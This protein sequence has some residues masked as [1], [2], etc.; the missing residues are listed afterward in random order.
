MVYSPW[1]PC[2]PLREYIRPS[3]NRGCRISHYKR[4]G[5]HTPRSELVKGTLL[6]VKVGFFGSDEN[7]VRV[8]LRPKDIVSGEHAITELA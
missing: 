3:G 8:E 5:L 6:Q 2:L 4:L 7:H 1:L